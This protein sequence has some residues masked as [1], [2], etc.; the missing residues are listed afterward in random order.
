MRY[1]YYPGCSLT[2]SARKLDRGLKKVFTKLGHELLEIPDWNCCGAFEF[3]DRGTLVELSRTNLEKSRAL[4]AGEGVVA[5]CPACYKNLREA[6]SGKT[7]AVYH[8]LELLSEEATGLLKVEQD[9]K[10]QVF[11]PY[12]G[13][14]LMRPEETAIS[15]KEVIETF[16]TKL[17][18]EIDG[19]KVKAKCCGGNQFFINKWATEKLSHAVLEGSRG[20]IVLFCPLCHMALTSFSKNRKIIYFTDLLLFATGDRTRL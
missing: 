7:Q 8:P 20:I 6:H 12:Y 10:G 1:A 14:L 13:C 5:P 18:G 2:G 17:G 4:N 11:T 19:T 16:I 3:G 15:N 9:L